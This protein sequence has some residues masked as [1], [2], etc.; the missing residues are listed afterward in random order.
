M[1]SKRMT[2]KSILFK[3]P[4]GEKQKVSSCPGV[5]ETQNKNRRM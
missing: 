2:V 3:G 5:L 4:S 1:G